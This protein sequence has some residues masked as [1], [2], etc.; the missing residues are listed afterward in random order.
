MSALYKAHQVLTKNPVI[1]NLFQLVGFI[2]EPLD[3]K[4]SCHR[5]KQDQLGTILINGEKY[6][7]VAKSCFHHIDVIVS[8]VK[9]T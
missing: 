9:P 3:A 1:K 6:W 8:S 5:G 2:F 4:A 7:G